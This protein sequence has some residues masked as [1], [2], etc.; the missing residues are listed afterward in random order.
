MLLPFVRCTVLKAQ[1]HSPFWP[2]PHHSDLQSKHCRLHL[3]SRADLGSNAQKKA[4][5]WVTCTRLWYASHLRIP[6][7]KFEFSRTFIWAMLKF[8]QLLSKVPENMYIA[9]SPES[10]FFR[11]VKGAEN[12]LS[13][14]S[15]RIEMAM[16][17]DIKSFS[18]GNPT[19]RTWLDTPL[20]ARQAGFVSN[21][22][23]N[24]SLFAEPH[25]LKMESPNQ[26]HIAV[27]SCLQSSPND[28]WRQLSM[29]DIC[30]WAQVHCL[31]LSLQFG[32]GKTLA[33]WS[34]LSTTNLASSCPYWRYFLK[35]PYDTPLQLHNY[36]H[37]D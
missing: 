8:F 4:Q 36:R 33:E 19:S 24:K 25:F 5:W 21:F 1:T 7:G 6:P 20:L 12:T 37:E 28:I 30:R 10:F 2:V 17:G 16:D 31:W 18:S 35:V 23:L 11:A 22:L 27:L 9:G 26:A 29:V 13:I 3:Q 14:D 15:R 32:N 34:N